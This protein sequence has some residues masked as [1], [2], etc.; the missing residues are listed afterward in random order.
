MA[1]MTRKGAWHNMLFAD[2]KKAHL[3]PPCDQDVYF[4]LPLEAGGG[5]QQARETQALA[6]RLQAGGPGL[7]TAL[8]AEDGRTRL[9]Q[10]A[11]LA[12]GFLAC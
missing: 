9:C 2:V 10:R 1:T 12:G 5:V 6:L 11:R 8:L 3:N 4:R 7:G